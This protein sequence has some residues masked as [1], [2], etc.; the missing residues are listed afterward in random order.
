[1]APSDPV[2]APL[3]FDMPPAVDEDRRSR[4]LDGMHIEYVVRHSARRRSITLTID[5]RGLR[6]GAPLR[7]PQRRIDAALDAHAAWILRKLPEWQ[8]RRP[9]PFRWAPGARIMVLGEPLVLAADPALP[10]ARR[11]ANQLLL[12][13]HVDDARALAD[14]ALRWLRASAIEWFS[15]RTAHFAPV[16][17]VQLPQIRLSNARTRW[18][19]CHPRGRIHLNWRLIHMPQALIDYVVVHELAHLHEPNHSARFWQRVAVVLPDHAQRRRTLRT[20][21]HRFLLPY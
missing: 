14:T 19:T 10:G 4:Q 6:I 5:E 9:A 7:T 21:A 2:Q 13:A 15:Q 16:L 1:M 18:G 3:L 20:D 8:A 11:Q 12:P 17:G